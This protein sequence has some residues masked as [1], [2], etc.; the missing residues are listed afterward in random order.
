MKII[1]VVPE[2]HKL[3]V[4]NINIFDQYAEFPG[5]RAQC[6]GPVPG[7]AQVSLL[8]SIRKYILYTY[9]VSLVILRHWSRYLS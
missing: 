7:Q 9:T 8:Q 1:P 5:H 2:N 4:I 3:S 6:P